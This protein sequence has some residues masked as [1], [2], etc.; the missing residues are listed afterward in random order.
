MIKERSCGTQMPQ[1]SRNWSVAAIKEW[2]PDDEPNL[3]WFNQ[4][5]KPAG[6]DSRQ[7]D[8]SPAWQP[9]EM[10]LGDGPTLVLDST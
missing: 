10:P 1:L 2:I 8:Q 9:S 4:E 7:Y 5:R 3:T 6:N